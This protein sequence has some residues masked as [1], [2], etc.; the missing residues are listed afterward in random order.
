V[1]KTLAL[2]KLA[3]MVISRIEQ[4]FYAAFCIKAKNYH[5]NANWHRTFQFS[6]LNCA[7]QTLSYKK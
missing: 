3:S 1:L 5:W 2:E 4:L 6:A 7:E